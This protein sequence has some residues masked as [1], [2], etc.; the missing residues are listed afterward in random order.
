MEFLDNKRLLRELLK[1]ADVM[2]TVNGGVRHTDYRVSNIGLDILIEVSNPGVSPDAFN[3]TVSGNNLLINVMYFVRSNNEDH[4]AM[5]PLFFK[6]VIIPY[7]VD[8]NRIE[9]VY[10]KGI[11]KIL[12]PYNNNLPQKPFSVKVKNRDN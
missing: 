6:D 9:A 8:I 12:L 10:N 4:P 11:F 7:Y 2:N 3:F 1:Q 5:Y